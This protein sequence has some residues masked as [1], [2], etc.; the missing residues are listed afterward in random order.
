MGI[1]ILNRNGTVFGAEGENLP[2]M[3]RIKEEN[4]MT[5]ILGYCIFTFIVALIATPLVRSIALRFKIFARPNHRTVHSGAVPKLG[6]GAIFIAFLFG[7]GAAYLLD[8]QLILQNSSK[9]LS[10][11]VGT[12]IL[13]VMG[14]FDDK[15]DLDCNLKLFIE[16]LVAGLATLS[17]WRIETLVLPAA[18]EIH[19]GFLSYPITILWIVGVANAI[20]MVDGLDGL[21]S[22]IAIVVSI[23][24]L[25]I[26]GLFQNQLVVLLS[27]LLAGA[28]AGFLRYNVNPASI[29][30][31]DSG[32]LSLGFVLGCMTLSAATIA[33]GK[34]ALMVPL[35]LL[36]IPITDTSLAIIRRV[37]RGIHPFHADREHIHHRLVRLGLS[38]SGAAMFMVGMSLI[39][40]IMAFLLAQGIHTDVRL[41]SPY[42][43]LP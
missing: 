10:L 1:L 21:A 22:G 36:G 12:T 11:I 19:L 40:G 17:G 3:L 29:F 18:Q 35:L 15:M 13:F 2:E 33:P 37:R 38:Q 39:L 25:A 43:S 31:G 23:V 4:L 32:S 8:T 24:S 28:V 9:A 27:V 42:L 14:T 34:M 16:L 6:G 30:M 41:F 7:L 20:N 5:R 26:A